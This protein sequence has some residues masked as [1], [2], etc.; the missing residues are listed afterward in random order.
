MMNLKSLTK[1]APRQLILLENGILAFCSCC[2]E[3]EKSFGIIFG[4]FP[5]RDLISFRTTVMNRRHNSWR[6]P[7]V[8]VIILLKT[9]KT[10]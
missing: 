2:L 10:D 6:L 7:L 5:V 3:A 1:I 8:G 9:Y 4:H